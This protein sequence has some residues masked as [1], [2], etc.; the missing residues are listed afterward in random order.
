[1]P[2]LSDQWSLAT[3]R[4]RVRTELLDPSG[5]WWSDSELNGYIDEWQV[6]LQSKFEFVWNTATLTTALATVT[7]SNVATDMLR[8]D[9]IYYT[10]GTST[11]TTG[12]LTNTF[13]DTSIRRL[14]PRSILDLDTIQRDWRILTTATGF[15]PEISYQNDPFEVSFWPPPPS[16]GTFTFEYPVLLNTMS[17]TDTATMQI[18][19]WTRYSVMP[20]CCYKAFKRFGP[21]QD[22][23][24]AMRRKAQFERM[25]KKYRRFYDNYF[26]ARPEM[27]RPGRKYAG[28]IL[29]PRQH[30][31]Q[32]P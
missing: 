32:V 18:P 15:H 21:N 26:P 25:F 5:K 27:L 3:L 23:P 6:E 1:M 30:N 14:S 9:A 10:P 20:F 22:I 24:K 4:G 8:L 29:I 19:A 12:T 7:L 17:G 2:A 28:D 31:L 16:A 13:T 11:I